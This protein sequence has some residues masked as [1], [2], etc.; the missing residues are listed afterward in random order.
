MTPEEYAKSK[1][2]SINEKVLG[3]VEKNE[4]YCPCR[5]IKNEDTKCPCKWER[6]NGICIC[7]LFNK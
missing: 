7:N 3:D 6:E 4:G 5:A 2:Y 1:N